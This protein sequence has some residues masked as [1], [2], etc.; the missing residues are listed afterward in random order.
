MKKLFIVANWKSNETE[1]Q[2]EE[3]FRALKNSQITTNKEEREVIVCPPFILLSQAKELVTTSHLSIGIGAQD[4]SP[5]DSGAHTGEE[6]PALVKEYAQYAI[7]G[8]SE[9]R[10]ELGETDELLANKV[11]HALQ[12]GVTPI[13]CVQGI[14]TPI[15][16]GVSLVAYE[17]IFAIGT[18][19]PD[20][21]ENAES[22]IKAIKAKT[23]V[24]YVL[25]GGSV[26]ADNVQTFTTMPAIDGVLVGGASL[27]PEKFMKIVENA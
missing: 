14:E 15:P 6:P 1:V 24:Q 7:I 22:V 2:A 12:Q 18:G 10:N 25:Y 16:E 21:P 17:P 8:H 4:F 27:D 19:H 26:T 11:A 9:R 5:F 20:T 3:W 23:H 13:F